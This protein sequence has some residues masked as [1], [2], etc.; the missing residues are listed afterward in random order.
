MV[1][2]HRSEVIPT[3]YQRQ[4][5]LILVVVVM[6]LKQHIDESIAEYVQVFVS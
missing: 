2:P 4:L 3:H 1:A 5:Q 6:I